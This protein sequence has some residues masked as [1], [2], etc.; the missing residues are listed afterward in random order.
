ML[1]GPGRTGTTSLFDFLSQQRGVL[2]SK[3]KETQIFRPAI[4]G[5]EPDLGRYR[6][7][8]PE[9]RAGIRIEASPS[10]FQGGRAVAE[11]ISSA[12]P[13][14]K[15]VITLRDPVLRYVSNY[16]HIRDKFFFSNSYDFRSY[17]SDTARVYESG[18]KF[19]D[20]LP[21]AGLI[22]SDYTSKLHDWIDV[23][24]RDN[25][26][27]CFFEDII[28]GDHRSL[29]NIARFIGIDGQIDYTH[30]QQTNS[31]KTIRSTG[32]HRLAMWVAAQSSPTL[33]RTPA[34]K[35]LLQATYYRINGAPKK[36]P[37][38]TSI[39][40]EAVV[41]Q[42]CRSLPALGRVLKDCNV[43]G[44]VPAWVDSWTSAT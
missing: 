27:V 28:S 31:S 36:L 24:G 25:V 1:V 38:D 8:F 29:L 10:Y 44:H 23:I 37:D 6:A 7:Q 11:C 17:I 16:M 40:A 15:V 5:D 18:I 43:A 4:F 41:R 30:F 2:A 26:L 33:R 14:T 42:H 39:L 13:N 19:I 12:S 3:D 21:F 9:H 35:R 32:L 20:D 22:E 34:V